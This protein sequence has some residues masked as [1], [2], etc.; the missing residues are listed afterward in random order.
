VPI[1]LSIVLCPE[2]ETSV[3]LHPDLGW[4]EYHTG[5]LHPC[6]VPAAADPW[7]CIDV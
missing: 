2:C 5:D 3:Y 7:E 1:G 6:P 4:V